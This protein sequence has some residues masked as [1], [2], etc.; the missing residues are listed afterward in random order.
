MSFASPEAGCQA[1]K[2]YMV[3]RSADDLKTRR[4]AIYRWA[5]MTGGLL[6]RGPDHVGG[7]L[8]G[9]AGAPGVFGRFADNVTRFYRRVAAESLFVTYVIIPPQ[10]DRSR[11]AQDQ[12]EAFL[13]VGVCGEKDGGILI[14]GAQMLGTGTA[15]S[16]HL[17]SAASSPSSPETRTTPS[18]R[19]SYTGT[20]KG[21]GRS[22]SKLPPTCWA[23]RRPR[24][25]WWPK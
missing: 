19:Y 6:G 24:S 18:R 22:S 5:L 14:R 16:D 15:V 21:Y 8:A 12:E 7:F 11:T 3:P 17:L 10:V 25:G 20:W 4:E 9:F 1:N 2:V 23:T 13:Q